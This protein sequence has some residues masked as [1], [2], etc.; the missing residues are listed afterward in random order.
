MYSTAHKLPRVST[1][2]NADA[3][4]EP[5]LRLYRNARKSAK[6]SL[7]S[8]PLTLLCRD[9]I[10]MEVSLAGEE[11][12]RTVKQGAAARD[13]EIAEPVWKSVHARF[14]P[15][16]FLFSSESKDRS[17]FDLIVSEIQLELRQ[18][19]RSGRIL[20]ETDNQ[21]HQS[22]TVDEREK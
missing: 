5:P 6:K 22:A 13:V 11:I 8:H 18:L 1:R 15:S 17:R 10:R 20:H 14:S 21:W 12:S 7:I 19:R 16:L 3:S 2:I 9:C 4:A